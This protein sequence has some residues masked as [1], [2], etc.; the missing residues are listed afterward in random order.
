MLHKSQIYIFAIYAYSSAGAWLDGGGGT[1]EFT[2]LN[3]K[4]AK[5]KTNYTN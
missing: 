4:A 2:S 3:T 1:N 5:K